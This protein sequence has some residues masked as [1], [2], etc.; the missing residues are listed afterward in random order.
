MLVPV[1]LEY[2]AL[3]FGEG[4]IFDAWNEFN[5]GVNVDIQGKKPPLEFETI[6]LPWFLF[7]WLCSGFYR[8]THRHFIWK[9]KII[10]LTPSS[11]DTLN[12]F[13]SSNLAFLL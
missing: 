9:K 5:N 3:R 6:L 13:V 1:L 12:R 8:K 10:N 2:A 7:N 4:I 11:K